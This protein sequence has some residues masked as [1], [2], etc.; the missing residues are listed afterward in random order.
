MLNF[1]W[2]WRTSKAATFLMILY[3]PI[4]WLYR[5]A[6]QGDKLATAQYERAERQ[7]TRDQIEMA[8]GLTE[9]WRPRLQP[10]ELTT[11]HESLQNAQLLLE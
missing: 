7:M 3:E 11:D 4:M 1:C 10:I 2:E 6:R 5:S 8:R 9:N